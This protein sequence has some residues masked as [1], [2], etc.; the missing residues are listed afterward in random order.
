MIK[1]FLIYILISVLFFSCITEKKR[2]KICNSC[3]GKSE[4]HDSIVIKTVIVPVNV[5]GAPGP[6]LYLDNPCKYLCDSLGN[7]KKVNIN[8]NHNGQNLNINTLGGGL[9][10]NTSTKDSIHAAEVQ[11]KETYHDAKKEMVKY[12]PCLNERTFMDGFCRIWFY[13][14]AFAA[15][16]WGLLTYFKRWKPPK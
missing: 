6:T 1:N 7:L 12:L 2:N 16:I 9:L 11:R 15:S 13:I 10:I 3:P 14:T 4:S 8:V 5:P